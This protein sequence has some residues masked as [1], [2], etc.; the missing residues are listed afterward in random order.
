[1]FGGQ[2]DIGAQGQFQ[3]AT[4]ANAVDGGNH[5]LVEPA[6]FLQA[7]KAALAIVAIDSLAP[8]CGLEIPAGAKEFLARPGQ[9][10][11]PQIGV[12]TEIGK[13]LAHDPAG[14]EIDGIGAGPVE[15]DLQHR[16][17]AVGLDRRIGHGL[18]PNR[19]RAST[20][21]AR[22]GVAI[23]GLISN[24]TSP[25][26]CAMAQSCTAKMAATSAAW[27]AGGLPR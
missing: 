27:W 19:I 12:I 3:P 1:M 6:Q 4:A 11:H 10:R 5:G 23:S 16:A 20:A 14:G 13:N 9:D 26:L 7:A 25:P 17:T 8:C 18:S 22:S 24:S 2:N 21:T 15:R